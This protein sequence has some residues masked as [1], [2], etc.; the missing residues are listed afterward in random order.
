MLRQASLIS[1]M[2]PSDELTSLRLKKRVASAISEYIQRRSPQTAKAVVSALDTLCQHSDDTRDAA[3][4]CGLRRLRAHWQMI[5]FAH[6]G[7]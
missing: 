6:G 7:L 3:A 4:R 1:R 5:A 2:H